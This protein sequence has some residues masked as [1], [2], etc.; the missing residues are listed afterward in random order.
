[1]KIRKAAFENH[2]ELI[3]TYIYE[4]KKEEY[5]IIA[6]PAIQ[7]SYKLPYDYLASVKEEMKD[8]IQKT[9]TSEIADELVAKVFM[10]IHEM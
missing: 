6:V 2:K 3:H 1:M 7:W 4:D 9:K 5:F 10:W 8:S